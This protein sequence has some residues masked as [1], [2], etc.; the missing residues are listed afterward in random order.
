VYNSKLAWSIL[1]W[2]VHHHPRSSWVQP[3]DSECLARLMCPSKPA[4]RAS[5]PVG[6]S[7]PRPCPLVPASYTSCP[8]ICP[9][10]TW[11]EN[12]TSSIKSEVHNVSQRCQRKTEPRPQATCAK[13][14]VTFGHVVLK[15]SERTYTDR[16]TERQTY[17][18]QYFTNLLRRSD[19]AQ[20]VEISHCHNLQTI[21]VC[22][23][24]IRYKAR[25]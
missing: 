16:Q 8:S 23:D 9:Q 5:K 6:H 13:N 24:Q 20:L 17:S 10:I 25:N 11:Y 3:P 12:M 2:N 22:K 19:N 15:L 4:H 14:L 1:Q 18:L 21:Q 7:D